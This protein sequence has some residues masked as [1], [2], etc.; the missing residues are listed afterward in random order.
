M[1]KLLWKSILA[2]PA[3]L[4]ATL[5]VAGAAFAAQPPVKTANPGVSQTMQEVNSLTQADNTIAQV[6]SV[7]QLS[8]VQPTD[9]AFQALQ[10][11]VERYGCIAG[12]PNGTFRGNR[13]MTRYEFAAGLNACLDK[14][15]ELIQA[16][17][18]Q[19]RQE[20]LA[21][22]QKL[23]DEF[24]PELAALRG[25]VDSLEAR[26]AKLE[27]QQF[28]TTTKLTAEVIFGLA[29]ASSINGNNNQA[30]F[31]S[32]VRLLFNT[33]FTGKDL[34]ETRLTYNNAP[35]F[36]INA[37]GTGSVTGEGRLTYQGGTG[38]VSV[39][40]LAYFLPIG[41]K[42]QLYVAAVG[43]LHS[44]Y[45]I[46]TANPYNEGYGGGSG[47]LS[48]F[49]QD[50][51]IYDIGG[52]TG[53]AF[54]YNFTPVVGFNIGYLAGDDVSSAAVPSNTPGIPG[55]TSHGNGL[56]NGG[57]AGLAQLS[58]QPFK[59]N[60][61]IALTYVNAYAAPGSS[62][63]NYGGSG[64]TGVVGTTL[65]NFPGSGVIG[66]S[67]G[68]QTNSYALSASYQF[69]PHFVVSA[70]GDYTNARIAHPAALGLVNGTGDIWAYALSLAFPD[71]FVKGNLAGFIVGAEPYLANSKSIIAGSGNK[72]PIH[73]EGYYKFQVNDF[74]SVTP[75]IIYLVHP[76]QTSGP[77]AVIGTIRT[78]FT[79]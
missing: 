29:D 27:A 8:D 79:F 24:G 57:Y 47:A 6:T 40:W 21:A 54:S 67:T 71:A 68:T 45:L 31:Q 37:P 48:Y 64:G 17:D 65:A 5:L 35:L 74:I 16:G 44:D 32:R 38:P 56:F 23:E 63:F 49:A 60:L 77:G 59:G 15:N 55:V 30:V 36:G 28:S 53:A 26:T 14:M 18:N 1:S 34:L 61:K 2:G 43:G 78:T 66:A 51:S 50:N 4:G 75:G 62:I 41:K 58:F 11:L 10:S 7:S 69:T 42:A 12:Y 39:D 33:S 76:D 22:I 9:W 3:A 19:V 70:W 73:I 46:T 72:V 25:R 20:D 13:A 52:G